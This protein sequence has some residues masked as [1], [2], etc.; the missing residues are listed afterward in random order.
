ML[1]NLPLASSCVICQNEN[2]NK[3][4]FLI[5]WKYESKIDIDHYFYF[6]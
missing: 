3:T 1:I 6:Y 2:K 5:S 4:T